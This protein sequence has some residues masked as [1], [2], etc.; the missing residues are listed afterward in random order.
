MSSLT[1]KEKSLWGTLV[2]FIA[3]AIFYFWS[4]LEI[5][6][7]GVTD[8]RAIFGLAIGLSVPFIIF[9]IIYHGLIAGF[10]PK[11]AEAGEDERDRLIALKGSRVGGAL[12]VVGVAFTIGH[13]S[14][15][16]IFGEGASND[17]TTVNLLL[18][19]LAVSEIGNCVS[20]LIHY[21]RGA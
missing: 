16:A 19:S 1:F 21:R 6:A 20:Q 14:M 15:N 4:V 18:F 7:A 17:F 10:S 5:A 8:L 3:I 2:A 9:A 12:L 13:I 11:D